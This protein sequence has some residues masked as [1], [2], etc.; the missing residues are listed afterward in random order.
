M[1][2]LISFIFEGK[3]YLKAETY[4]FPKSF[5]FKD[6]LK[7]KVWDWWIMSKKPSMLSDYFILFWNPNKLVPLTFLLVMKFFFTF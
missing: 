5:H 6:Y 1:S 4:L 7:T 3:T 2:T